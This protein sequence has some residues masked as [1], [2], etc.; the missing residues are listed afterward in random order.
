MLRLGCIK[1]RNAI[2]TDTG[3]D[4]F[5]SCTIACACM[6]VLRTSH[7]K[8]N[9]IGR[10]AVNGYRSRSNYSNKSM[11]WIT[12]CEKITGVSYRHA[13]SVGGEMYLKKV[14][15]WADACYKSPCHEYVMACHF[16]GCQTC[17]DLSTMNTH[18][19]KSMDD[20]YRETM[21]WIARVTNSG[22]KRHSLQAV[23]LS[24]RTQAAV[25]IVSNLPAPT[26]GGPIYRFFSMPAMRTRWMAGAVA[27]KSG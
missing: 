25:Q 23:E 10:V 26:N 12:Y 13:W 18:L 20:L 15:V 5:Q 21:R 3:I 6:N 24:Q 16:H 9:S 19:N 14:K 2:I 11:E 4:P 17:F 27:H 8:P 22:S 1:F 7:L